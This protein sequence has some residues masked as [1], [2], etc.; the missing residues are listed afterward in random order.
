[1]CL[2]WLPATYTH[3]HDSYTSA[4]PHNNKN[5]FSL[6]HQT[7]S[8]LLI[9]S[10]MKMSYSSSRNS[11]PSTSP[12]ASSSARSIQIGFSPSGSRAVDVFP[13]AASQSSKYSRCAYP[14][15]PSGGALQVTDR[16]PSSY[17]S[18]L[19]GDDDVPYLSQPPAPPRSA[20]VWAMAQPL[21]PPVTK[22][23]RRSSDH[24]QRRHSKSSSSSKR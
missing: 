5:T 17:I 22:T 20:E 13:S 4:S 23:K 2:F 8:A 24:N 12:S 1:V 21:L 18:D 16:R 7:L 10:A 6:R 3:V 15:W 9:S 19:F 14:S 11:T